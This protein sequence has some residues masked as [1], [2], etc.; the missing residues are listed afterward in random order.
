MDFNLS[1]V[2]FLSEK[3]FVPIDTGKVYDVVIIGGGPAGLTAA[4]YC[5]RKGVDTAVIV[6][7]IGGQVAETSSIENYMGYRYVNGVEL[8]EKFREQVQQFSIGYDEGNSVETIEDD[9]IKK[10]MLTDGRIIKGKTLIIA[11]GKSWR[12]LGVPGEQR[13]TGKGVAY[14]TICDAPLF[15]GKK[16]VVVGGGNSGVEAAIDLASVAG[17]VVVLQLLDKLTADKILQDKLAGFSNVSYIYSSSVQEITG[18]DKVKGVIIENNNTHTVSEIVTDGVFVEIGLDPNSGFAKEVVE[19]N[20]YGEIV[21]D[22]ACRT[23]REGVFAAG[24]VTTVP[25]K[26]IIIAGGE[27]AKAALSACEYLMNKE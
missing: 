6:N 22:C 14:C 24:D 10:V 15:A 21:V 9:G 5:M 8:V 17:E 12:K 25:F 1:T 18:D 20:K 23:S 19:M 27:G 16:V 3:N 7:H 13:L 2:S 11:S 4:V 26:Q